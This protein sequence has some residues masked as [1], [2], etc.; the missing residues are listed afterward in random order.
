[1]V[2]R[3][4]TVRVRQRACGDLQGLFRNLFSSLH[5]GRAQSV[6]KREFF[7]TNEARR[8]AV[9]VVLRHPEHGRILGET[10]IERGADGQI[11]PLTYEGREWRFGH[12]EQPVDDRKEP[13]GP[14]AYVFF[15]EPSPREP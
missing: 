3:G 1:M 4:S 8:K 5:H 14:P 2:R 13:D 9:F 12:R 6:L 15:M 7:V 11:R 10:E